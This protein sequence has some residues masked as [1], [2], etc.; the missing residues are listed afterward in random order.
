MKLAAQVW[1]G[2]EPASTFL[3]PELKDL[4][5]SLHFIVKQLDEVK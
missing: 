3:D 5:P 2:S 1:K 4:D